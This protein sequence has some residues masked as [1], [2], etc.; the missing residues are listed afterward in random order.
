MCCKNDGKNLFCK[1]SIRLGFL[2][3][4]CPAIL[5]ST[6]EMRK[7]NL[8]VLQNGCFI[9]R[10]WKPNTIVKYSQS[11]IQICK[12]HFSWNKETWLKEIPGRHWAGGRVNRWTSSVSFLLYSSHPGQLFPH[13]W[14]WT[15]LCSND[16][17]KLM[18]SKSCVSLGSS[19]V[20]D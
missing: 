16:H 13:L 3:E 20:W 2:P 10:S 5:F 14:R 11:I 12:L 9:D 19:Y 17:L 18:S 7:V 15:F 8:Q 4:K 6:S 1:M